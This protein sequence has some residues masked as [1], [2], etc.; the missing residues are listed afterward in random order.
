MFGFFKKNNKFVAI[1]DGTVCSLKEVP[2]EVFSS[3]MAGD[4]VAIHVT[5]NTV[6]APIDGKIEAIFPSKHA[7][8][9]STAKGYEVL[10]HV[11]INTVKMNGE[12][13]ET[14]VEAGTEVKAGTP[15]LS[16]DVNRIKAEGYSLMTPV[17][18]TNSDQFKLD[19]K[20]VGSDAVA[21]KTE[22]IVVE[23]K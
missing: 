15:V 6:V 2:D 1:A 19:V 16:V 20:N 17:L 23:K 11:G 5:G 14:L 21:G 12:G 4:G 13:F 9:M 18:I 7:F 10:V 8:T 3:G 22:V